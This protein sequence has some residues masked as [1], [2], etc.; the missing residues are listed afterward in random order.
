M[1]CEFIVERSR[2]GE[3]WSTL[4]RAVSANGGG[5]IGYEAL[6]VLRLEAGIRWFGYD[7]DEK[8]IPHE[9]GL[10]KTHISYTKG[11]YTGQEIVERVRSR[12]HVNRQIV[13]LKFSGKEPPAAATPLRAGDAE[14]GRVT[15]AGYSPALASAIGLGYVRR[16]SNSVGNELEWP[17]GTARVTELPFVK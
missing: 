12:G 15:R 6:N 5:P 10:E 2:T 14:V 8:Q 11:C 4:H 3:L 9:A 17:G 7:F 13:G 16:E 1:S